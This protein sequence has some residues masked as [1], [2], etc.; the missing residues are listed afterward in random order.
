MRRRRR[1]LSSPPGRCPEGTEGPERAA[2]RS[3]LTGVRP[4]R[5]RL[6]LW[7]RRAHFPASGE[8]I[9]TP[10][11]SCILLLDPCRGRRELS[12][13]GRGC[14]GSICR[15]CGVISGMTDSRP[16]CGRP[17]TPALAYISGFTGLPH[18][19]H[20][21]VPARGGFGASP[22]APLGHLPLKGEEKRAHPKPRDQKP[23]RTR[24]RAPG[25]QPA[26]SEPRAQRVGERSK[27]KKPLPFGNGLFLTYYRSWRP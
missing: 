24:D 6:R 19:S 13:F 8:D 21:S 17:L 2:R 26:P 20:S 15:P 5:P 18:A 25:G 23:L 1:S 4:L 10:P 16:V 9:P 7:L 14:T 12:L 3:L 11:T 22:S 27:K